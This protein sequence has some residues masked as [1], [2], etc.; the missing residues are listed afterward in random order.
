MIA[1]GI[2]TLLGQVVLLREVSVAFQGSELITLLALGGWLLGSGSG[3]ALGRST[4]NPAPLQLRLMMLAY[5][6]VL[7]ASAAGSRALRQLIDAVPG[8]SLPLPTQLLGAALVLLPSACLAGALF[9]LAARSWIG[10]GR[11]LALAYGLE[12]LGALAGGAASTGLAMLGVSNLAL[13]LLT[14]VVAATVSAVPGPGQHRWLRAAGVAGTMLLVLALAGSGPLGHALTRL[15]H[16][17]L[18]ASRDTPY[19]RV[20]VDQRDTQVVIYVDGAL[21]FESQGAQAEA[22]VHSATLQVQDPQRV[23]LLGGAGQGWLLPLLQHRPKRIDLVEPDTALVDLL[24][25]NLPDQQRWALDDPALQLHTQDPRSFLDTPGRYDLI[26][27]AQRDPTSAAASRTLTRE[28]FARCAEHLAPGG[29]LAFQLRGA[30]NLWTPT[31]VWRNAGIH[32]ALSAGFDDILVLPGDV[33][34]WL[35][36]RSPLE[37]SS[38]PLARRLVARGIQTDLVSE[39]WLA[40]QLGNDRTASI[41]ALLADSPAPANRDDRPSSS[42]LTL[43]LW[44]GRFDTGLALQDPA[45][46]LQRLHARAPAALGGAGLLVLGLA[47]LA[48]RWPGSRR[49]GLALAA[50]SLGTLLESAL[51]VRFQVEQGV[52]PGHLGFLL[53]AFMAGLAAGSMGIDACLRRVGDAA[54]LPG[55]LRWATAAIALGTCAL[56]LGAR[57]T[58]SVLPQSAALLVMAGASTAAIFGLATRIGSPDQARV[59]GRLYAADLLGGCAGVLLATLVL[60]PLVGL[61][62]TGLSALMV[63]TAA[64]V[65]L[66]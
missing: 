14:G 61:T 17:S 59:A 41:D 62:A 44:L 7:P 40:Y 25:D 1:V 39:P 38:A 63:A 11:S 23:L 64:L 52:L 49:L 4:G 32:R 55:W 18:L 21:S 53:G 47:A 35:A 8:S 6:V 19:G 50:G 66:R 28:F 56:V 36:S 65:L 51:L 27:V 48:R 31:L 37:R 12:S 54:D 34:T 16:P 5:A 15:D 22:F 33:N 3:A 58:T 60:I 57:L 13:A 42:A 46:L 10:P 30:E 2:V 9:R 24:K 43:L 29:V 26:L 45:P 20:T